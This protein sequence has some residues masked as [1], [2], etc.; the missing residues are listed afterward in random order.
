M[1]DQY[2]RQRLLLEEQVLKEY[3][4][5]CEFVIG[6]DFATARIWHAVGGSWFRLRVHACRAYPDEKPMV[7]VEFPVPL[8]AYW[9][10]QTISDYAPSHNYHVLRTSGYGEVQICHFSE[11]DWDAS[12]TLHLVVLKAKLWLEAY[13]E[14]HMRTGRPICDFFS[15]CIA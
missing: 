2:E 11:K 7:H 14:H 13:A 10:G 3:H 4:P 12:K 6:G 5:D 1:W 8:P 9:T 15:D